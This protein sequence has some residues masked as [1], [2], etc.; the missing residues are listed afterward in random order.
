MERVPYIEVVDRHR[1]SIVT[2]IE[3]L[4]PSNKSKAEDRAEYLAKRRRL[5]TGLAHFVEIDLLR[6]GPR[7]PLVGL[8]P[9]DY[10]ALVSRVEDRPRVGLWP[11]AVRDPLPTIRVP[12]ANGD[13]DVPLD[14][15]APM[16]RVYDEAGY[17]RYVYANELDPPLSPADAAWAA[18]RVATVRR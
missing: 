15:R 5:R 16:D 3:L 6:G 2:V 17:G 8:P 9:C 10:Y 12:L 7:M 14:L 11:I 18:E 1:Q 13:A 4:S